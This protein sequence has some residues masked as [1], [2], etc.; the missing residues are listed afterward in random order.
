[1][2]R[3]GRTLVEA[4]SEPCIRREGLAKVSHAPQFPATADGRALVRR[5]RARKIDWIGTVLRDCRA[6]DAQA[7]GR[8]AEH[9][10]QAAG[11]TAQASD[12][13]HRRQ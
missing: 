4:S 13:A 3:G 9:L 10:G 11:T 2:Q 6:D 7:T 8:I 1:M 12:I 5:A